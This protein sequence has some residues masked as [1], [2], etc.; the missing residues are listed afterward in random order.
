MAETQLNPHNELKVPVY[1]AI[2][3]RILDTP[4]IIRNAILVHLFAPE[5]LR[6]LLVV[7]LSEPDPNPR[8]LRNR[9]FED[10]IKRYLAFSSGKNYYFGDAS[11][12]RQIRDLFTTEPDA[13]CRY[14]SLL[15]S[16][17]LKGSGSFQKLR[18]RIVDYQNSEDVAYRTGDCHGKVSPWLAKQ[19]GAK[20]DTP[21]QFRL[22]WR[23]AWAGDE[24]TVP[25][26]SFLAKGTLLV[27]KHLT[28][29]Q[30]YDL[31]LDRSSI[32]GLHKAALNEQVPCGDYALP[33]VV[34]GN[35]SNARA[36]AY[37]NSWQFTIWCSEAAILR[38]F[39]PATQAKAEK[40]AALQGNPIALVKH[41]ITAYDK[42]QKRLSPDHE[43]LPFDLDDTAEDS[44]D[45]LAQEA[46]L[47]SILKADRRYHLLEAPKVV[48]YLT[49]TLAQQWQALAV[50]GG[51]KHGSGMALPAPELKRGNVCA[52]HLPEGEVIVTRYPIVSRDNIR[53]YQNVHRP[54]LMRT[55][56]VVWIHPQDAEAYHQAD[57]DGDQLLIT[58]ASKLP[59]I[60]QEVKQ[61]GEKGEFKPV[62][63][64]PK[65][66]YRDVLDAKGKPKYTSLAQVAVASSQNKVGLVA[67]YIGRVQ[68]SLP[69]DQ[70][71]PA[72]FNRHQKQLLN[73]LLQAL[74]IEV[75]YQKSAERLEDVKEIG[76]DRLLQEAGKWCAAHPC[77]FFDA[78]KQPQLYK[79]YSLP[80]TSSGAVNALAREII[81]PLWQATKLHRRDR[82]EY[83]HLL[84]NPKSQLPAHPTFKQ[85]AAMERWETNYL[86]WAKDLKL[87]FEDDREVIRARTQG[88]DATFTEELGRLY[89]SYRAEIDEL[90]PDPKARMQA[91]SALWYSQHTNS[92]PN[93]EKQLQC[94]KFAQTLDLGF[95]LHTDYQ[96]PDEALPREAYVLSVPFGKQVNRWKAS[97]DDRH[98]PYKAVLRSD[99]PYVDFVFD[100]RSPET[101][102]DRLIEKYGDWNEARSPHNLSVIPPKEY[103]D[104]A[105]SQYRSGV[106]ALAYS[107]LTE[108]ICQHLQALQVEQIKVVGTQYNAFAEESFT[109]R[110][111]WQAVPIT[112]GKLTREPDD[113]D[114]HRYHNLPAIEINGQILGTFATE[115]PKLPVGSTFKATIERDGPKRVLLHVDDS[116]I[117]V[118]EPEVL[119]G[120][121]TVSP[122][123]IDIP[124]SDHPVALS[125]EPLIDQLIQGVHAA[126]ESDRN[127]FA[128]QINSDKPW[129]ISVGEWDAFVRDNG[130]CLLR[131][132]VGESKQ[133]ICRFNLQTG[134]IVMPLKAEQAEE[135][136][137]ML[138]RSQQQSSSARQVNLSHQANGIAPIQ[139]A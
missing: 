45:D 65:R 38:D 82:H 74:Q 19:L 136:E 89:D 102:I 85:V 77:P 104:W 41:L 112:V 91:A 55:R 21:F 22:A 78:Y 88:N 81:N 137:R 92:E 110:L 97:L 12:T 36:N 66:A 96:L 72:L 63:Q 33:Q 69:A 59:H 8:D 127:N 44:S 129:K 117:Q 64:R 52:P 139:L 114:Y 123:A 37:N 118:P 13:A 67:T 28:K 46:R 47:L 84:P 17:C 50:N 62:Q 18:V 115:S 31:I 126:Y 9:E 128:D 95:S 57:F 99:L 39:G 27:D 58:P 25:D 98:L 125:A 101:T 134:E 80:A 29:D 61:A 40:L 7:K 6:S 35:R 34:M 138:E 51:F 133:T 113:P 48:D 86:S 111:W 3:Q 68:S 107:L 11:L 87:R 60:A 131:A 79:A 24:A 10:G 30:G 53:R 121:R 106:G 75:D 54:E 120:D 90:F 122:L 105:M 20:M 124:A 42:E 76:G 70:E 15:A 71:A 56:N 4:L 93:R 16:D 100:E 108:E 116:S 1:D 103:A 26:T 119:T 23:S 49:N 5:D 132:Q 109:S 130:D 2:A 73:R 14:G 83:Q 94:L 43:R 135:L 32:K